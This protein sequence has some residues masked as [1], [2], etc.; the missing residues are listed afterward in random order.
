MWIC[1]Y[2]VCDLV[3]TGH[4]IVYYHTI[5]YGIVY[6][7]TISYDIVQYYNNIIEQCSLVSGSF[8]LSVQSLCS[9]LKFLREKKKKKVVVVPSEHCLLCSRN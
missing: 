9:A 4:G 8:V 2:K 1:E 5:S 6:Y 3:Q 7:Y